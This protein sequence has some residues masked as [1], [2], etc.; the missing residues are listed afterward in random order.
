MQVVEPLSVTP[1]IPPIEFNERGA[2]L[3]ED[4]SPAAVFHAEPR[5]VT[6]FDAA[7]TQA[8]AGIYGERLPQNGLLL[9]IGAT[10]KTLLPPRFATQSLV[11]VGANEQE[12]LSNGRI[13]H[14]LVQDLSRE[15]RLP[16]PDAFFDG[17][18]CTNTVGYLTRPL[19]VFAE[20][21]RVLK[22]GAPFVIVWGR[23]GFD[24][25]MVRIWRE[26]DD[27]RRF[28]IARSYFECSARE[29]KPGWGRI[30]SAAASEGG[31][32]FAAPV[33]MT[34]AIA[35]PARRMGDDAFVFAGPKKER[36]IL[37]PE[38]VVESE[39]AE[40]EGGVRA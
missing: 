15:T 2:L 7:G 9:E 40:R 34:E 3:P 26:A 6:H 25:R 29:G 37:M 13:D 12:M 33:F 36:E 4:D 31:G 32:L 38:S 21:R 17:A 14:A 5:L 30:A 28:G 16:F 18:F 39:M 10:W 23:R 27:H 11:G 1:M 8:V 35:A 24:T 22:P 19:E 20:V